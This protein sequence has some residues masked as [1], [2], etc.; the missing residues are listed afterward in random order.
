[1]TANP[2]LRLKTLLENNREKLVLNGISFAPRADGLHIRVDGWPHGSG[3]RAHAYVCSCNVCDAH[4]KADWPDDI[5]DHIASRCAI[6]NGAKKGRVLYLVDYA[7]GGY[8]PRVAMTYSIQGG[9]FHV[10]AAGAAESV[11]DGD[12]DRYIVGLLLCAEAI[13]VKT[14]LKDRIEWV[15]TDE[16]AADDVCDLFEF[17]SGQRLPHGKVVVRRPIQNG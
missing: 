15:C 6:R 1:M 13:A 17:S 7:L 14:R 8:R 9:V 2:R 4:A 11:M 3:R 12:V 16:K 5:H 10:L